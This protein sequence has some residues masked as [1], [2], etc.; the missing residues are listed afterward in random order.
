M[1]IA[2]GRQSPVTLL[3]L[4]PW[5]ADER[6]VVDWTTDPG[7]GS[8]Q[9]ERDKSSEK[10]N[11]LPPS[12]PAKT[13][14]KLFGLGLSGPGPGGLPKMYYQRMRRKRSGVL[15]AA[16]AAV[17]CGFVHASP[18]GRVAGWIGVPS[19]P[20]IDEISHRRWMAPKCSRGGAG[21]SRRAT[22]VQMSM[23][24]GQDR[25]QAIT[26]DD[27]GGQQHGGEGKQVSKGGGAPSE[28][29][30]CVSQVYAPQHAQ[31]TRAL[32]L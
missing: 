13:Q 4:E 1:C 23:G 17:L 21:A 16:L 2:Q 15:L 12:S 7:S 28:D 31:N 3:D 9:I 26:T 29:E 22:A 32:K 20:R 14:I 5:P 19:F 8:L 18:R 11:H 24:S 6:L 25:R 10:T 27:S 30:W